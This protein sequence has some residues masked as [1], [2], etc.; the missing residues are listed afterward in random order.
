MDRTSNFVKDHIII[1]D[2]VLIV[3]RIG[4]LKTHPIKSKTF[5]LIKHS[6]SCSLAMSRSLSS[7]KKQDQLH[8]YSVKAQNTMG[9][10]KEEDFSSPMTL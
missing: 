4:E 5:Q 7:Y 8:G 9:K 6:L 2:K 10:L 1:E 3:G